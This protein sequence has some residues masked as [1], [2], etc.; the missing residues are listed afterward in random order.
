MP[1]LRVYRAISR[2]YSFLAWDILLWWPPTTDTSC[3][4]PFLSRRCGL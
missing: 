4:S 3:L 1:E 2:A